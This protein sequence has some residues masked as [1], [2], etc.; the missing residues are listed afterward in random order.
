MITHDDHYD[1][2][3]TETGETGFNEIVR[4]QRMYARLVACI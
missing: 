4:V 1:V 2:D 3:D